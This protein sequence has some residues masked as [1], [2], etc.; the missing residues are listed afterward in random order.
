MRTKIVAG[1]DVSKDTLECMIAGDR[2]S[3][4]T[5]NTA[6]SHRQLIE[7]F[8]RRSV[9]L[10]VVEATGGYEKALCLLLWSNDFQVAV[11]NPRQMRAFARSLGLRAKT[12]PIDARLVM[13]FGE[14]MDPTPTEPP[15]EEIQQIK[16]LLTRRQQLKKMIASEKN[17]LKA[18]ILSDTSRV[19]I[20]AVLKTFNAEVKAIDVK[21]SKIISATPDLREKAEKL[22]VQTGVGPVLL[23]TLLADM[24]ELGTLTRNQA[25][26]LAGVAPFARESG[27]H[28]G[29]RVIA[30]GRVRVRNALYMATIT[31]IRQEGFIKTFYKRLVSRG[32]PSKVAIVACMRKFIIHLNSILKE[33]P[34]QHFIVAGS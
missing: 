27:K 8:R 26:A 14:R 21:I 30:G 4:A 16:E 10:I 19:S 23:C 29:K 5:R 22:S 11:V 18:P 17:H 2:K 13:E 1:I 28:A 6:S 34:E 9:E 12:D 20:R 24:P 3:R 32:K 33:A 25:S 31:A 7:R 15:R